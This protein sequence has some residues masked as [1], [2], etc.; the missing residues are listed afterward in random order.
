M[1]YP[2]CL[3]DK[4]IVHLPVFQGLTGVPYFADLSPSSPLLQGLD[5]RDQKALQRIL[6]EKMKD[7]YNW[8]FS[9]YLERRDLLLGEC[10][11][12][13][14]EQRFIHLGLDV[15][16]P[17]G[18][19]LHSPLDGV[20][21]ER[22]YEPGEGNYGNYVLL[23]HGSPKFTTFYSFYGHLCGA[24]LP[25]VGKEFSAGDVFAEIGDFHENGNWFHHTH[26]QV[27]TTRGLKEGYVSKG[28]CSDRDMAEM[29]ELCPSPMSLFII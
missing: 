23:R 27:I 12:M 2:Y 6:D 25:E 9:P 16:V 14:K 8:G 17:L 28:Y 4:S 11:Q 29:N 3:Y 18:T 1:R 19:T 26:I 20:V 24:T 21:E 15:I 22:G 10:P 7:T 5:V 13:V